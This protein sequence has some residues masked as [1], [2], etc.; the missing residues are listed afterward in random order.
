[1]RNASRFTF[2]LRKIVMSYF[3]QII[4]YTTFKG[5]DHFLK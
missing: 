5:V 4:D 1:M 3:V 2:G